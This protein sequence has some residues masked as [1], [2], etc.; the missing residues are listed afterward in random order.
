[1]LHL[2]ILFQRKDVFVSSVSWFIVVLADHGVSGVVRRNLFRM[3]VTVSR[4][5]LFF[6]DFRTSALHRFDD[7]S[8]SFGD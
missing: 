4:Q 3:H 7:V 2:L 5:G 6:A 8:L 1:M